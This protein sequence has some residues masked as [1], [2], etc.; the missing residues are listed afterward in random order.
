MEV[1]YHNEQYKRSLKNTNTA[2]F[3]HSGD[4]RY[5]ITWILD[6]LFLPKLL[7]PFFYLRIYRTYN[8]ITHCL[9]RFLAD[10]IWSST[11]FAL[12]CPPYCAWALV[13]RQVI[14][15]TCLFLTGFPT[16]R[17]IFSHKTHKTIS[18]THQ[19][20]IRPIYHR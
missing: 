20:M 10:H 8:I 4:T 16:L 2:V 19:H 3:F 5:A 1:I 15:L 12:I 13:A 6:T 9:R 11:F 17:T 14:A 18:G 7:W